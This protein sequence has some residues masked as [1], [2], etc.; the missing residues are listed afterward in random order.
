MFQSLGPTLE[1]LKR[2][3]HAAF[4]SANDPNPADFNDQAWLGSFYSVD[5]QTI[6]ALSHTEYHGWAHKGECHTQ[7]YGECEYDTW[8]VF[9]PF[10]WR[11]WGGTDFSVPFVDPYPSP[12]L[13]P[14]ENIYMPAP[15]MGFVNA[16]NVYQSVNLVVATLW[17]YLERVQRK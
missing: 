17:D 16:I 8:N 11:G 15:Y 6:A 7:N 10:S 12:V 13:H 2:S 1:T 4:H 14:K 5:G 9:D 3:C